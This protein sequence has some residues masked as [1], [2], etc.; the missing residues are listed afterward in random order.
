M[1]WQG[2]QEEWSANRI[3]FSDDEQLGVQLE[4]WFTSTKHRSP[5]QHDPD[6]GYTLFSKEKDTLS[7]LEFIPQDQSQEVRPLSDAMKKQLEQLGYLE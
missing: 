4:Q 1:C 2:Y 5:I 3:A 7:V 6:D